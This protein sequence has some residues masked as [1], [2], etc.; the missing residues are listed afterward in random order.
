MT[1]RRKMADWLLETAL[2]AIE[3]ANPSMAPWCADKLIEE[4]DANRLAALRWICGSLDS[5]NKKIVCDALSIDL[6]DLE[7]TRRVL[8]KI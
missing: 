4:G 7:A 5:A 2:Q 8:R 6:D 1:R 3:K